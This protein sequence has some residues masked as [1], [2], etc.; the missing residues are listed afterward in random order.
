MVCSQ[1]FGLVGA[2]MRKRRHALFLNFSQ[3]TE[4]MP[5]G[6]PVAQLQFG[7]FCDL[8]INVLKA[9]KSFNFSALGGGAPSAPPAYAPGAVYEENLQ[10]N[11]NIKL[12]Y[13]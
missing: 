13:V 3:I 8:K 1:N 9:E 7:N 12:I 2:Q 5:A 10:I 6:L 11:I 4:I